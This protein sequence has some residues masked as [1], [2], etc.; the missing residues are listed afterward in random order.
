MQLSLPGWPLPDYSDPCG[1]VFRPAV[2]NPL[3]TICPQNVHVCGTCNSGSLNGDGTSLCFSDLFVFGFIWSKICSLPG[4][5]SLQYISLYPN[6]S[7]LLCSEM[8]QEEW[9]LL[10]LNSLWHTWALF[11]LSSLLQGEML[12]NKQMVPIQLSPVEKLSLISCDSFCNKLSRFWVSLDCWS[13]FEPS[14]VLPLL[15][16]SAKPPP[17]PPIYPQ[18]VLFYLGFVSFHTL[19][20]LVTNKHLCHI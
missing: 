1:W 19:E 4:F 8:Q 17:P 18:L 5:H 14:G 15:Q 11:W 6:S 3:Q 12:G 16:I 20:L 2:S 13:S 7:R 10:L 9:V